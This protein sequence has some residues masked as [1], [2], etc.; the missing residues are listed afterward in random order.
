M[1]EQLEIAIQRAASSGQLKPL[2]NF[3]MRKVLNDSATIARLQR[4][5]RGLE[6]DSSPK[7]IRVKV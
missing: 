6:V 5:T 3:A 4:S 7:T 1:V 2:L